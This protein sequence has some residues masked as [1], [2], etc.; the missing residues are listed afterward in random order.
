MEIAAVESAVSIGRG[1]IC[2]SQRDRTDNY[3]SRIE[4][5]NASSAIRV[6]LAQPDAEW[7]AIRLDTRTLEINPI[8]LDALFAPK[9]S[10]Q[11][12]Y[13][14]VDPFTGLKRL[15]S[16]NRAGGSSTGQNR[17]SLRADLLAQHDEPSKTTASLERAERNPT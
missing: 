2:P 17:H 12:P 11:S 15:Q 16:R 3:G 14:L 4:P 9:V 13:L 8:D 1:V 7:L 6:N 10:K 5:L